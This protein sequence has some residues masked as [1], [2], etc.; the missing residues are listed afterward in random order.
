MGNP[1]LTMAE[2][3]QQNG[4]SSGWGI[5]FETDRD[6]LEGEIAPDGKREA[7]ISDARQNQRMVD[8]GRASGLFV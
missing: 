8:S 2:R 3:R 4:V 7:V 5:C 1:R 6:K